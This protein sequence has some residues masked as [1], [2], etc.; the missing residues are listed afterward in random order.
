LPLAK[1]MAD[2]SYRLCE[3]YGH[4]EISMTVKKLEMPAY[5]ARGI[6]G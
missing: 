4:P 3:H 2:G 6:Q 1:L 5:D